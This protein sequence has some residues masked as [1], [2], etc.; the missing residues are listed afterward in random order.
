M[1]NL[2]EY[3]LHLSLRRQIATATVLLT[4]AA[5]ALW[6]LFIQ[7][8]RLAQQ[9]LRAELGVLEHAYQQQLAQLRALPAEALLRSQLASLARAPD[10]STRNLLLEAI[11]AA[12]GNQLETWQPESEPRTLTLLLG[13]PQFQP[14]FAE[15]AQAAT[16]FPV[17]F[18]LEAQQGWLQASFWLE[19]NDAL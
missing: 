11:L 14:L 18:L 2:R 13:W 16:P 12:R 15:L 7:P 19:N 4:V 8:Q 5:L 6:L 10:A 9:A 17:R 1:N 3:W